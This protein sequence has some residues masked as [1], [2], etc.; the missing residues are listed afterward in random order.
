MV[1]FAKCID[2]RGRLS[3]PKSRDIKWHGLVLSWLIKTYNQHLI[4]FIGLIGD[5]KQNPK[6]KFFKLELA[7][8]ILLL[9]QHKTVGKPPKSYKLIVE[10]CRIN[11]NIKRIYS[12]RISKIKRMNGSCVKLARTIK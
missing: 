10:F 1:S 2:Y 3:A 5:Y 8:H 7:V 4:T 6:N 12:H 11:L 9:N